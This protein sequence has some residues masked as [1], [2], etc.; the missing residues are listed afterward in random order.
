MKILVAS[1]LYPSK[2]YKA[3]GVFV[4]NFIIELDEI[5][6]DY[7]T[8][9]INLKKGKVNKLISYLV[10]FLKF[11]FKGIFS[12][13]GILYIHYVSHNAL[14]ALIVKFFRRNVK[15]YANAHGSD[16][17]PQTKT[18]ARM[19]KYVQKLLG[20]ADKII[21]PSN[22]FMELVSERFGISKDKFRMYPSGGINNEVFRPIEIDDD[23]YNKYQL[24]KDKKYIGFVSRIAEG[25]GWDV[26][27]N[28]M[29]KVVQ[30]NKLED[31]DALI[32][33]NGEQQKEFLQM[34]EDL[35]LKNRVK[36]IE[37]V[38]QTELAK[39][40][41]VMEV[42]VFPTSRVSESLGLV[43]IEAMATKTNIIVSDV[44]AP[45]Y[46]VDDGVNGFKFE[47]NNSE[48]LY[49]TILKYFSLNEVEKERLSDN[50]YTTATKYFRENIR[51]ELK[52]ILTN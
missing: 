49:E 51:E 47:V 21:V 9:F 8:V 5:G 24:D 19:Q 11:I 29:N 43:G 26:F 46:I 23:F 45:K 48:K 7:D 13:Y 18:Q 14:P 10:Y 41:N 20:K 38:P 39:L 25:K 31:L 3:L 4:K 52:D 22:Y 44:A 40:Y 32:V 36:Y 37:Q 30:S 12:K 34:I 6:L 27:L 2:D 35:G 50:A 42:F 15:I 1:N 17:M 28:A 16:V 33:G